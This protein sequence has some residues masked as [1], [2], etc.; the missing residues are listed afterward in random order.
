MP[1]DSFANADELNQTLEVIHN[2]AKIM[3]SLVNSNLEFLTISSGSIKLNKELIDV[4]SLINQVVEINNPLAKAKNQ[5]LSYEYPQQDCYIIG[6]HNKVF[7]AVN[8]IVGNAIKFSQREKHIWVNV[9]NDHNKGNVVIIVK[10][11][12]PGFKK[13]E[14]DTVFTKFGKHSATPTGDEISTG[15]GLL[16]T[17]QIINLVGGEIYLESEEGKGSTFTIEFASASPNEINTLTE[18]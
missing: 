5:T 11:E 18:V 6:D 12:G 4:I 2:A 14:V 16:I 10:D 7:Q 9:S 8:N 13:E 17:K 15:L 1:A 3:M